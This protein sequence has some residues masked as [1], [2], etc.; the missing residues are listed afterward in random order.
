M[1]YYANL[2]TLG[3]SVSGY[4]ASMAT[5]RHCTAAFAALN[6][7]RVCTMAFLI[8]I[9]RIWNEG[10]DRLVIKKWGV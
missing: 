2:D 6:Q 10:S 1:L 7:S 8:N 9:I 4:T 3:G 5:V